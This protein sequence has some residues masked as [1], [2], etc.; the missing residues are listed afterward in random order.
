ML[1]ATSSQIDTC[2]LY[3]FISHQLA[4]LGTQLGNLGYDREG[5]EFWV[6]TIGTVDACH[7]HLLAQ[8]AVLE[9]GDV[10]DA[11]WIAECTMKELIRG[12]F[13]P[14][15]TIQQLRQYDRRIFDLNE[16]I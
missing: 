4:L 15:E 12:S 1:Q 16:E 2:C 6:S 14:P 7:I 10:K 5:V 8:F 3:A 13:V 11:Q 9:I